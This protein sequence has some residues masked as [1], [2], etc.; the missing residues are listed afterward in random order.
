MGSLLI[1]LLT[2]VPQISVVC[3]DFRSLCNG[4][5]ECIAGCGVA[6]KSARIIHGHML[7]EPDPATETIEYLASTLSPTKAQCFPLVPAKV[8][9]EVSRETKPMLVC[10][11]GG[12][13][14][15]GC[16]EAHRV[17]Y[18]RECVIFTR[19]NTCSISAS[20][21]SGVVCFYSLSYE[22]LKEILKL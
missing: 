16:E 13:S 19:V 15:I 21:P 5:G 3:N 2:Q 4:R 7:D 8:Y 17:L 22:K 6:A 1:L 20:S 14:K 18:D 12:D 10:A 9:R 11:S